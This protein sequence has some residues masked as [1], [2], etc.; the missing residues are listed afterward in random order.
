[1]DAER[2]QSRFEAILA[3]VQQVIKGKPEVIRLSLVA[4]LAEGHILFEDVPGVGKSMLARALGRS[5][6]AEVGRIQCTPDMLPGDITGSSVLD[7]AKMTFTFKAGP[8]FANV[9]LADEINRA[10]PKT[11]SALLEAMAER[12]VTVDGVSHP[13]PRPFLVLATQNPIEL[14]GTFPL[15]EAQLDRFLFKLSIG[16]PDIDAEDEILRAHGKV[17]AINSLQPVT[18]TA[19]ITAMIEW[20]SDVTVSDAVQRFILELVQGTR[21][22]PS[23][24]LGGSPRASLALLWASRVLAASLGREDVYPDDVKALLLPVLAHRLLLTPDATLRGETIEQ[25]LERV[26]A[27]V[28]PPLVA[29]GRT[30]AEVASAG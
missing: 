26:I 14:A 1:M 2:F 19:E 23:L 10:T 6:S 24:Q 11:Q 28:K 20:A 4:M 7:T 15:P 22:D 8:I 9:L 29:S 13:L 12:T 18:D 3:N 16:Y 21:R 27:K 5:L 30:S 17:P 25:V